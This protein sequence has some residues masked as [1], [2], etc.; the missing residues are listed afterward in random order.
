MKFKTL[1][2]ELTI[3][4]PNQNFLFCKNEGSRL[5]E[6]CQKIILQAAKGDK[7]M[8]NNVKTKAPSGKI[9]AAPSVSLDIE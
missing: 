7:V 1:S 5:T 3:A 2:Y 8:V 4:K 9:R 6:S